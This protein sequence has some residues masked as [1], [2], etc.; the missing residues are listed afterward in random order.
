MKIF[1]ARPLDIRDAEGVVQAEAQLLAEA[2]DDWA[3]LSAI[4][5]LRAAE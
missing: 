1:A 4:D 5:R 3:M 2:S